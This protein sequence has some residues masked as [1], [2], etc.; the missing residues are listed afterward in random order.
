M[1][2]KVRRAN[3]MSNIEICRE[4]G[5][6]DARSLGLLE[7]GQRICGRRPRESR[8]FLLQLEEEEEREGR[9]EEGKG[10][11]KGTTGLGRRGEE[12]KAWW[13]WRPHMPVSVENERPAMKDGEDDGERTARRRW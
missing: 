9:G 7:G 5:C 2:K 11:R 12:R 8:S 1:S 13:S 10:E 6:S 3:L 4:G